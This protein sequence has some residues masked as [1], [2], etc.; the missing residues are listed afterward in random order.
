MSMPLFYLKN[1][2]LSFAS[3]KLFQNISLQ[4]A[5]QD[6]ICLIGKNGTG[7]STLVKLMAGLIEPDRGEVYYHPRTR[8]ALLGQTP[9]Y[10]ADQ[11]IYQYVLE[12]LKLLEGETTEQ[13]SYLADIILEK[14]KLD[15][16]QKLSKL[17]GGKLR[18]A[19]LARTLI[20]EPD[21]LFLDEPT[22]HLDIESIEWLEEYLN[23]FAGGL[24]LI[25]HDRTFLKNISNKTLW[26]DRGQLFDHNK[27]YSDFERWSEEII[28]KEARELA[29]LGKE[30][31]KENL[32]LQQGVTARRKRNQ[33]RLA[34]LFEL[35]E[36][37]KQDKSR[38]FDFNKSLKID[39][40]QLANKAK[41]LLIMR[42]V[43]FEY[44]D[45]TPPK[46][47]LKNFSIQVAKGEKI[48]VMGKNGAGKTTLIKLITGE[49]APSAGEIEFGANLEISYLDQKRAALDPE[50][51]L[52]ETMLPQGGDTIFLKNKQ[53]H[54]VAYLKDFLFNEA[55][56]RAKVSTLS[57]GEKNRLL[58]A[59]LLVSPGNFLILDEPTNDLD[60][61]TL[62]L[63][64]ELLSDYDGSILI[65]SHDR[66]FLEK[67]VTRT[68]IIDNHELHDLYG[69]YHDY[70]KLE[71]QAKVSTVKVVK[72][73]DAIAQTKI[74]K[75]LSYKDEREL[76]LLPEKLEKLGN[77][78]SKL[79][80]EFSDP[81]LYANNPDKFNQVGLKISN[82]KQELEQSELRWLELEEMKEKLQAS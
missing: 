34:G 63:L 71:K 38:L 46:L 64:L 57:G 2:D 36:K 31:D 44:T 13:K 27:G 47:M 17:S 4:V 3:H 11:T 72:K 61:D 19:D 75:K 28:E 76:S 74:D 20:S 78:L 43:S 77:E 65:V 14:L 24:V 22:N 10:Q 37:F 67:L 25:S 49:L 81:D 59:R 23:N 7:K 82:I 69:G 60:M 18:R 58:L 21:L 56:V 50:K 70:K 8:V 32:W 5:R 66:D 48:G 9:E 15:G 52:W 62:D 54:V 29:R 55:Q 80:Q 30:L 51:T 41:Q 33:H 79:E 1:V 73:E 35:R 68:I 16:E 26:L 42:N 40:G 39:M 53:K 45:V 12:N 6:K